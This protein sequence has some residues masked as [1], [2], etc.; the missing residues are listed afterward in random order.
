MK[1]GNGVFLATGGSATIGKSTNGTTWSTVTYSRVRGGMGYGNG[2]W[3]QL[4]PPA[5]APNFG[6]AYYYTSTDDAASWTERIGP[7]QVDRNGFESPAGFN[8]VIYGGGKWVMFSNSYSSAYSTD[9]INWTTFMLPANGNWSRGTYSNGLF[10]II[11]T[12]TNRIVTSPDGINWTVRS[13]PSIVHSVYDVVGS[14]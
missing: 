14:S 7:F 5:G 11:G 6:K 13:V 1:Y 8:G 12:G 3:L 10:V 4:G 2:M 9:G